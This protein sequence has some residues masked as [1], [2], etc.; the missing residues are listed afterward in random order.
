M[1]AENKAKQRDLEMKQTMKCNQWYFGMK[2]LFSVIAYCTVAL[3]K[4]E[5]SIPLFRGGQ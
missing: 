2:A 5:G 3:R 4:V 1:A